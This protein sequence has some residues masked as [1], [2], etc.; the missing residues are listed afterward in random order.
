MLY[1]FA[2]SLRK[3]PGS[4]NHGNANIQFA[5]DTRIGFKSSPYR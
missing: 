2:L 5:A 3:F 1:A 4:R